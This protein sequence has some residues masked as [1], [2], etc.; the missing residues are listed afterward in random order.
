MKQHKWIQY[1]SV[2]TAT[3]TALLPARNRVYQSND[4]FSTQ[5]V[6]HQYQKLKVS[7]IFIKYSNGHEDFS[8]IKMLLFTI[9]YDFCQT[10]KCVHIS[11]LLTIVHPHKTKSVIVID[12]HVIP[13]ECW[14]HW[15]KRDNL[16]NLPEL[17]FPSVE[18]GLRGLSNLASAD[19]CHS[20][21]LCDGFYNSLCTPP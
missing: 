18:T 9:I 11:L 8:I 13:L 4:I 20:L 14:R 7:L 21:Y 10:V 12:I 17:P 15:S 2:R 5:Y 16:D 3:P 6:H 1:G 19:S